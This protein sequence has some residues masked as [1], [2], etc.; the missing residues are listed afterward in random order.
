MRRGAHALK[1]QATAWLLCLNITWH[2]STSQNVCEHD[3][4][5]IPTQLSATPHNEYVSCP[6]F[7]ATLVPYECVNKN[8]NCPYPLPLSLLHTYMHTDRQTDQ[9]IMV[10]CGGIALL[11]C[12]FLGSNPPLPRAPPSSLCPWAE[13]GEAGD[14]PWEYRCALWARS[15]AWW[16]I[17]C[18]VLWTS[19][20]SLIRT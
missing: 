11:Q 5:R 16:R 14:C 13:E 18:K 4:L 2:Y 20:S 9:Q 1:V 15:T 19:N 3:W 8:S 10:R 12:D 17:S 6:T 7:Y